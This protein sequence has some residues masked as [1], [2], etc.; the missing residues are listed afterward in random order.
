MFMISD[1]SKEK[2]DRH[3]FNQVIKVNVTRGK[4]CKHHDQCGDHYHRACLDRMSQETYSVKKG[5]RETIGDPMP[6]DIK[7]TSFL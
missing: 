6:Q 5:K 7:C 3:H 4:S 1:Y 2:I